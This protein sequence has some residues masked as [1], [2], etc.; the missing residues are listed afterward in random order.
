M[1]KLKTD[2][3]FKKRIVHLLFSEK[4]YNKIKLLKIMWDY[5]IRKPYEMSTLFTHIL[6]NDSI[7]L[8]IGAN[9]GQYACRLNKFVRN[10][11]G[12][13]YSFEPVTENF[14]ALKNMKN[15]LKLTNVTINQLGI[16]N[17]IE[18]TEINIPMFNNGLIVGTQATLLNIDEIKHR[19]ESI[20]V[21]TIDNYVSENLIRKIDFIKCDT[22]GNEINVLEGGKET[23][24]KYLPILSFEMS[25]NNMGLNWILD[26]GY[27]LFYH[28]MQINKLLKIDKYQ[29]GNL[30][31]LHNKHQKSLNKIIEY[32]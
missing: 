16:S 28:D 6:S 24:T 26:L 12:H 4:L 20:K 27:E 11:Y 29:S 3:Y 1:K 13:I 15:I 5:K 31:F 32:A 23:I 21:T 30:I 22:E 2:N 8:D 7:V 18:D 9:M 17:M 14:I 25:Y 10:G 19:T